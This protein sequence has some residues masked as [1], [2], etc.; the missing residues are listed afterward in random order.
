MA[1]IY[2]IGHSTRGADELIDL[3]REHGV[4]RLVDVRRF[5]TSRRHPHFS[6]DPLAAALEG[7]GIDYAHEGDLGGYRTPRQD[8]PNTAWRARG[9]QAYADHMETEGFRAAL[10]RLEEAAERAPTAIMCAEAVPWRCHRQLIA[11]ALVARGHR[12]IH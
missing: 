5:P 1:T 6:R 4:T 10:E 2:T 3:L 7:V 11:D 8:S 12:V 9:F